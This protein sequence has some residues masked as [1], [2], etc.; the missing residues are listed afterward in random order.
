[1]SEPFMRPRSEAGGYDAPDQRPGLSENPLAELA[2]LVGKDD[3]FRAR[4][5][6]DAASNVA[7]FPQLISAHPPQPEELHVEDQHDY[8]GYETPA[9]ADFDAQM[10]GS[11]EARHA[12]DPRPQDALRFPPME[13]ANTEAFEPALGYPTAT[14]RGEAP[15]LNADLWAEGALPQA[16]PVDNAF[17]APPGVEADRGAPRR[18]LMVLAAVLVLTGG[19]LGATFLMR[20]GSGLHVGAGA[21]PTIMAADT[22][23]KVQSPEMATGSI[24]DGNTALL[25][26]TGSDKV[27]NARVVTNNEQPVDLNQLPKAAAPAA[28]APAPS[29][30]SAS[31]FPEPRKVKTVMVRPDG[32]V[33]G[34]ASPPPAVSAPV[35]M[36]LP[37]EAGGPAPDATAAVPPAA[38]ASTPKSTARV[39]ATP[40]AAAGG[41]SGAKQAAAPVHPAKPKPAVVADASPAPADEAPA[42]APGTWSVQLAA[43]PSEAEANNT[44]ARLQ[45]KFSDQ[46][47]GLKPS[48]HK[49][50]SAGKSVYRVRVGSLSQDDAKSL[51]A[52]LQAGGGSCFVV[53][54]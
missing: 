2:R 13:P 18:T 6:S 34:E 49:A 32:S 12:G 43:P 3:P 19:G 45:K 53:K 1:M 22:P 52:K 28:D 16:G 41:A 35:G 48:I 36:T 10:R 39:S 40:T 37:V 17:E 38:Q 47:G 46:L 8:D 5:R 23:V 9:H 25:E 51:C 30:A 54:N 27:D 21:P 31:P 42:V 11:L 33:V 44:A 14:G 7:R 20:E 15:P 24:P 26:K 50:D 29:T 4:G